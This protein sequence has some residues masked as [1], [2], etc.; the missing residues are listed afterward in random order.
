MQTP[1]PFSAFTE[2]KY[3]PTWIGISL[4]YILAWMPFRVRIKAGEFLGI[5]IYW[6][7]K[8]RRYITDINIG[9]CFPE[10]DASKQN[11]LVRKIFQEYR[12]YQKLIHLVQRVLILV[13][14][15]VQ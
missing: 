4:L 8:E 2:I 13:I 12:R 10:L 11:S 3:W 9:I 7:G 6:L 5:L 15:S 1:P 14:Y